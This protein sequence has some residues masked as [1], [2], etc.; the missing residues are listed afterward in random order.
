MRRGLCIPVRTTRTAFP[1]G[2]QGHSSTPP[3]AQPEG[4]GWAPPLLEAAE[5]LRPGQCDGPLCLDTPSDRSL[6]ADGT[7]SVFITSSVLRGPAAAAME[8]RRS[9]LNSGL[10]PTLTLLLPACSLP[11]PHPSVKVGWAVGGAGPWTGQEPSVVSSTVTSPSR[12]SPGQGPTQ[13]RCHRIP[14]DLDCPN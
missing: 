3:R 1:M 2:T 8:P 12:A 5:W 4:R 9:V 11:S 6:P 14:A 10:C 13:F 7:I